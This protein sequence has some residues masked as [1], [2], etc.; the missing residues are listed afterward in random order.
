MPPARNSSSGAA[1]TGLTSARGLAR[2][3]REHGAPVRS[4]ANPDLDRGADWTWSW[5][6]PDSGPA[7]GGPVEY[8]RTLHDGRHRPF[9]SLALL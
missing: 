8:R 9:R 7:A 2:R 5:T 3:A 1:W 4:P 6:G